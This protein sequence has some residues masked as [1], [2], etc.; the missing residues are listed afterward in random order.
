MTLAERVAK[1]CRANEKQSE[2]KRDAANGITA[3]CEKDAQCIKSVR[4]KRTAKRKTNSA[5][6][7]CVGVSALMACRDNCVGRHLPLEPAL[8]MQGGQFFLSGPNVEVRGSSRRRCTNTTVQHR[9]R[10]GFVNC[11]SRSGHGEW[12]RATG[13]CR[14]TRQIICSKP[15]PFSSSCGG[16]MLN[17]PTSSNAKCYGEWDRT[18]EQGRHHIFYRWTTIMCSRFLSSPGVAEAMGSPTH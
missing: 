7:A 8:A 13:F 12:D 18:P 16:Q 14:A 17:R 5:F 6:N 4:I 1:R 11:I 2:A 15:L 10:W 9:D 3:D